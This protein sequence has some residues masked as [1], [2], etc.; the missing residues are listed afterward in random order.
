VGEQKRQSAYPVSHDDNI[1]V[2]ARSRYC[3][4]LAGDTV[5]A[6]TGHTRARAPLGVLSLFGAGSGAREQAEGGGRYI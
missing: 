2:Q 4:Q 6:A 3:T 1:E 5:V